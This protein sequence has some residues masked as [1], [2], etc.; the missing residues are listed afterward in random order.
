MS[1]AKDRHS[2]S[3]Q[4]HQP[5]GLRFGQS[6]HHGLGVGRT[7][8]Q[9]DNGVILRAA[10]NDS[11]YAA[12][13]YRH[14]PEFVESQKGIL[15]EPGRSGVVGHVLLEG[16]SVQIADVFDDSECAYREFAKRGGFRTILGVPLLRE[17]SPIGIFVV[18]R[19]TET[20]H[21]S[22]SDSTLRVTAAP[23]AALSERRASQGNLL[24]LRP[25]F[26][27]DLHR[28][29]VD[30][31]LGRNAQFADDEKKPPLLPVSR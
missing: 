6:A 22:E 20:R 29:A 2:R 8:V 13:T 18:G 3:A 31:C 19:Y 1:A 7:S 17:G 15:F 14:T 26:F 28:G 12:A 9:A 30:G 23:A 24:R 11:Y 4:H 10:G 27:P 5:L 16:K 21:R 25:K